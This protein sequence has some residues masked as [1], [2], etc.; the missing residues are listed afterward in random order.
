[1]M[2]TVDPRATSAE[3]VEHGAST[4]QQRGMEPLADVWQVDENVVVVNI[5]APDSSGQ[6]RNITAVVGTGRSATDFA[7]VLDLAKAKGLSIDLVV[8]P[9]GTDDQ[10]GG[11]ASTLR[12]MANVKVDIATVIPTALQNACFI[13]HGSSARA[14]LNNDKDAPVTIRA[15][16][17]SLIAKLNKLFPGRVMDAT[18]FVHP[19]HEGD[20]AVKIWYPPQG[21]LSGVDLLGLVSSGRI[22]DLFEKYGRLFGCKVAA[23][24]ADRSQD[25][26]GVGQLDSQRSDLVDHQVAPGQAARDWNDIKGILDAC[27]HKPHCGN[28]EH[29]HALA[30]IVC[31]SFQGHTYDGEKSLTD[32]DMQVGLSMRLLVRA[33][34]FSLLTGDDSLGRKQEGKDALALEKLLPKNDRLVMVMG[35]QGD[36]LHGSGQRPLLL[37]RCSMHL[38]ERSNDTLED[39]HGEGTEST[40]NTTASG[41]RGPG[42]VHLH[43]VILRLPESHHGLESFQSAVDQDGA[44]NR[45]FAAV[46]ENHCRAPST[47]IH[48]HVKGAKLESVLVHCPTASMLRR[49]AYDP[50][51]VHSFRHTAVSGK[52]PADNSFLQLCHD[53]V[54]FFATFASA[55]Q[56]NAENIGADA[57]SLDLTFAEDMP[58]VTQFGH[59]S[60]SVACRHITLRKDTDRIKLEKFDAELQFKSHSLKM[61]LKEPLWS[62]KEAPMRALTLVE[63]APLDPSCGRVHA[64]LEDHQLLESLSSRFP[65][66]WGHIRDKFVRAHVSL[67]FFPLSFGQASLPTASLNVELVCRLDNSE[68]DNVIHLATDFVPYSSEN[69]ID[70]E[71]VQNQSLPRWSIQV[72]GRTVAAFLPS[73]VLEPQE[74]LAFAAAVDDGGRM[75]AHLVPSPKWTIEG[76]AEQITGWRAAGIFA[77]KMFPATIK[78]HDLWVVAPFALSPRFERA[79][80]HGF[81]ALVSVHPSD[82]PFPTSVAFLNTCMLK[83]H[84]NLQLSQEN[85]TIDA[86]SLSI[87]QKSAAEA[88]LDLPDCPIRSAAGSGLRVESVSVEM[89][90]SDLAR[91]LSVRFAVAGDL[92]LSIG[93][94]APVAIHDCMG[95]IT[96]AHVQASS[97]LHILNGSF[98][99]SFGSARACVQ[100][101][102]NADARYS[103]AAVLRADAN[104]QAGDDA[105]IPRLLALPSNENEKC[106]FK[107][108]AADLLVELGRADSNAWSLCLDGAAMASF[109]GSLPVPGSESSLT[110]GG[111]VYARVFAKSSDPRYGDFAGTLDVT[112][113]D[114]LMRKAVKTLVAMRWRENESIDFVLALRGCNIHDLVPDCLQT[115]VPCENVAATVKYLSKTAKEEGKY[116]T[117]FDLELNALSSKQQQRKT[118]ARLTIISK[119]K[120]P[121]EGQVK[122]DNL[123]LTALFDH[124]GHAMPPDLQ[125]VLS[126]ARIS[127]TKGAS[128]KKQQ[129][130]FRIAGKLTIGQDTTFTTTGVMD[131]ENSQVAMWALIGKARMS[132]HALDKLLHGRLG[133]QLGKFVASD[134]DVTLLYASNWPA[135][136]NKAHNRALFDKHLQ[137]DMLALAWRIKD[138]T[139]PASSLFALQFAVTDLGFLHSSLN[140]V[141]GAVFVNQ[142]DASEEGKNWS[143]AKQIE[144]AEMQQQGQSQHVTTPRF[145]IAVTDTRRLPIGG[146]F[147]SEHGK[148]HKLSLVGNL[149]RGLQAAKFQLS[150]RAD[151]PV[152]IS[153]K[154][155]LM[156][157]S[158]TTITH[159]I[160]TFANVTLE[161]FKVSLTNCAPDQRDS[162]IF[163]VDARIRFGKTEPLP[164]IIKVRGGV[165]PGFCISCK[166]EETTSCAALLGSLNDKLNKLH[167]SVGA[168]GISWLELQRNWN[169]GD[170]QA[171][172]VHAG[173]SSAAQVAPANVWSL[174][175][176]IW[177]QLG[178][179]W[180]FIGARNAFQ[181][182]LIVH[183][184]MDVQVYVNLADFQLAGINFS[185]HISFAHD[186]KGSRGGIDV[187]ADIKINGEPWAAISGTLSISVLGDVSG[188]LKLKAPDPKPIGTPKE[189]QKPN[190]IDLGQ[191]HSCLSGTFLCDTAV[192]CNPT[193]PRPLSSFGGIILVRDGLPQRD[194]TSIR[195]AF[196]LPLE[197]FLFCTASN[198]SLLTGLAM[199]IKDAKVLQR[200]WWMEY[201]LPSV[202]GFGLLW[203]P[204]PLTRISSEVTNRFLDT[205]E[206]SVMAFEQFLLKNEAFQLGTIG[207]GFLGA[208]KL[209]GSQWHLMGA[210]MIQTK[211]LLLDVCI[212]V[213][214]DPM[215][216]RFTESM[217]PI[218]TV[219][220]IDEKTTTLD[221]DRQVRAEFRL[222]LG[223]GNLC[224][225]AEVGV[226]VALFGIKRMV[227][228]RMLFCKDDNN[229]PSFRIAVRF[230]VTNSSR[231]TVTLHGSFFFKLAQLCQIDENNKNLVSTLLPAHIQLAMLPKAIA[232][233]L[234]IQSR[235]DPDPEN[236]HAEHGLVECLV[237]AIKDHYRCYFATID[238]FLE[239]AESAL[240]GVG[241]MSA[242]EWVHSL[243]ADVI[244]GARYI[245]SAADQKIDLITSFMA[246]L[247]ASALEIRALHIGGAL[248]TDTGLVAYISFDLMVLGFKLK[249]GIRIAIGTNFLQS[250]AQFI[251]AVLLIKQGGGTA[252][253]GEFIPRIDD[254]GNTPPTQPA[255]ST[256]PASPLEMASLDASKREEMG[257]WAN[258]LEPKIARVI[259]ALQDA[260]NKLPTTLP[261][262]MKNSIGDPDVNPKKVSHMRLTELIKA[263]G[264][265][266]G[267]ASKEKERC[268]PCPGCEELVVGSQ[269]EGHLVKCR[270]F[271]KCDVDTCGQLLRANNKR[272]ATP[273]SCLCCPATFE[274]H[275]QLVHHCTSECDAFT[276]RPD[277]ASSAAWAVSTSSSA[278]STVS[279]QVVLAPGSDAEEHVLGAPKPSPAVS[280]VR[281]A[282]AEPCPFGC[283]HHW[284]SWSVL[285]THLPTCPNVPI[286]CPVPGCTPRHAR[287]IND[288]S[289]LWRHILLVCKGTAPMTCHV[290][291]EQARSPRAFLLHLLQKCSRKPR[292]CSK[293]GHLCTSPEDEARHLHQECTKNMVAC[294]LSV[295]KPYAKCNEP[296][297]FSTDHPEPLADDYEDDLDEDAGHDDHQPGPDLELSAEL[298]KATSRSQ[299]ELMA[300]DC[301][302]LEL[303]ALYKLATAVIEVRGK[304]AMRFKCRAEF[305]DLAFKSAK[306]LEE[307]MRM[308][309]TFFEVPCKHCGILVCFMDMAKHHSNEC[310]SAEG[311]RC[312]RECSSALLP[313]SQLGNHMAVDCTR[314]PFVCLFCP[315][316]LKTV[317]G[318]V[319][320]IVEVHGA[321]SKLGTAIKCRQQ[322]CNQQFTTGW[323]YLI[324][325]F[326]TCTRM[327]QCGMPSCW[328]Q[329]PVHQV[330]S[331]WAT[332]CE[333]KIPNLICQTTR[334]TKLTRSRSGSRTASTTV[335]LPRH[336]V[337]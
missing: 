337:K 161:L 7:A 33:G 325:Q 318:L 47:M 70:D 238:A 157:V 234:A 184:N 291:Q 116:E 174:T 164:L 229:A 112:W 127:W 40:V 214:I 206:P 219:C 49:A 235:A 276:I 203:K 18:C 153:V 61:R 86:A 301:P 292:K 262:A 59:S 99:A 321:S 237:N 93:V 332:T 24:S 148:K 96:L 225:D 48:A 302:E 320:H 330:G 136:P 168:F 251:A 169:S 171:L 180:K 327:R 19:H 138:E 275:E 143:T 37:G 57:T 284:M 3:V 94:E 334:T 25:V 151:P 307:H 228:G 249:G 81:G 230:S 233:D 189:P 336:W 312:P 32:A 23:D 85:W 223:N 17:A 144:G 241:K 308:E 220:G 14:S 74:Q 335:R 319:H 274:T 20:A 253:L 110:L 194:Q 202:S 39:A 126:K 92:K 294:P 226:E 268:F 115:I 185:A 186:A 331:H 191:V 314:A 145:G 167:E 76:M 232:L 128:D 329:M 242:V 160:M 179:C 82:S 208:V 13:V 68:I 41:S 12:L 44:I 196:D 190:G 100:F 256:A 285:E 64:F 98:T 80:I 257:K 69:K 108:S 42:R 227:G 205:K 315:D 173:S 236:P 29:K 38:G 122:I 244:C 199:F 6:L 288:W 188:M 53:A 316:R 297:H 243:A 105:V 62:A 287:P 163:V 159:P 252:G 78:V 172:N 139:W 43:A 9:H 121:V 240:H 317:D 177:I 221:I 87:V 107:V 166:P 133:M 289:S 22:A 310:H 260:T 170:P 293:C 124:Q 113:G 305:C 187:D 15:G 290:C 125:T 210:V 299:A 129:N 120:A 4:T 326:T 264:E 195:V 266:K 269:L 306:A 277:N 218:L 313:R 50:Y 95:E 91:V 258:R 109:L 31:V 245:L 71:G 215:R 2:V 155:L 141:S 224:L 1:M 8:I 283:G 16:L 311:Q 83:G 250:L 104:G 54:P 52:R 135:D 204:N 298:L 263:G 118:T 175:A 176:Q 65:G 26:A 114:A 97:G 198:I 304:G 140:G 333:A 324:H 147:I 181:G 102:C 158:G 51:C 72:L 101:T 149:E 209:F 328:A 280:S 165:R 137:D 46:I 106:G 154:D 296:D 10:Y 156:K 212:K 45:H 271:V 183:E 309:C 216:I 323:A 130:Q 77:K 90:R 84:V 34:R 36:A 30:E 267:D 279:C 162:V 66:Q 322:G 182:T 79:D 200:L 111:T 178:N 88:V 248:S 142:L 254:Q 28:A 21:F 67:H 63:Q 231:Q 303:Y 146:S 192:R 131:W 55:S 300:D 197:N 273:T 123:D 207:A 117:K 281:L 217:D 255:E 286:V 27:R 213:N 193:S 211:L 295:C 134:F 222:D 152:A 278:T 201:Y 75:H 247:T 270:L 150:A 119:P 246:K 272:K 5:R 35:D 73:K 11:L 282:R 265:F 132:V 60:M 239:T 58:F 89:H 103:W 261:E 56:L 259:K